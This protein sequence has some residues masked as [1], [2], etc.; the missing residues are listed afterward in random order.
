MN[1]WE[2]KWE[3]TKWI[4]VLNSI[5]EINSIT[6]DV[7]HRFERNWFYRPNTLAVRHEDLNFEYSDVEYLRFCLYGH[8]YLTGITDQKLS[9][10]IQYIPYN[11]TPITSIYPMIELHNVTTNPD[12]K[13][14]WE[15]ESLVDYNKYKHVN[16]DISRVGFFKTP[17]DKIRYLR[18][19]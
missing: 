15:G 7:I 19:C 4:D 13:I 8:R 1:T 6:Q 18:G 16:G 17:I 12:N 5:P 9:F 10:G 14:T 11:T 2:T 3:H